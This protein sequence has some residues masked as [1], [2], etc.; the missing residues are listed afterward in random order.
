MRKDIEIHINTGD[1]TLSPKNKFVLR[2]FQWVDYPDGLMRYIY[3]EVSLPASIPEKTIRESGFY[4]IIPYTPQYKEFYIRVRRVHEGGDYVYLQNPVDGSEWFLVKSGLYGKEMKNAYASQL[5]MV[6]ETSYY[7][8]INNGIAELYS[9][10]ESDVNII[11][12]NRQNSNMLL[13][14]IPTNNYRY[15]LSG[16]GLIRWLKSAMSHIELSEVLKKE[17]SSDGMSV[18]NA[19]FDFDTRDLHLE[20]DTTNTDSD[21]DL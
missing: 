21:G 3:G 6:S 2:P 17:F 15:P 12:A 10:S 5:Y 1:I 8:R 19:S 7:I 9:S 14:C 20:V 11:K 4:L 13:K 16:V 18:K